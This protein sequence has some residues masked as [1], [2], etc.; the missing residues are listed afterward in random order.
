MEALLWRFHIASMPSDEEN[1]APAC[2]SFFSDPSSSAS[3]LLAAHRAMGPALDTWSPL[4]RF[5]AAI[6]F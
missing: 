5:A 2:A 1:E 4:G 6:A 3:E